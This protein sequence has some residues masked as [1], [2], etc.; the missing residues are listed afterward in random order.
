MRANGRQAAY[1]ALKPAWH[2]DDIRALRKGKHIIPRQV[3]LILSDLCNHDCSF[4]SY[5]RS[6]GYSSD[7]FVLKN[8][9]GEI[10]NRNP[11]RKIPTDKVKEIIRDCARVGVQAMQFTGGGEPTVH[12]DHL[13][14]FAYAQDSGLETSLVTNG[15]LLRP[16]WE[17]V[18]SKMKWI[19][20]SVDAGTAKTYASIRGI[21]EKGFARV[22]NNISSVVK[23]AS[24]SC[25]VGA[26]FV[27]TQD[28]Y[29]EIVEA[30]KHFKR[31]GVPYVRLSAMF[32]REGAGHY[33]EIYDAIK[34]SI[35]EAKDRFEGEEFQIV[36]LFGNRIGDLE[37]GPPDYTFCG[38]QQFNCYIGAD[39][40]V[41]R[42]CT[43]A[44]T[45]RGIVG[46]LSDKTFFNWMIS[47]ETWEAYHNFN[48]MG[49]EICQFNDKNEVINYL[50]NDS[51]THVNFV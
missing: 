8:D 11:N 46:D 42:C 19:R 39:L 28:N 4:C 34:S 49:C 22:L 27:V 30:C 31:T 20:I 48:A 45:P 29:S 12:P 47:P 41:Y 51:P 5:R 14:L 24:S 38:Y 43:T 18:F 25:L 33:S 35:A 16:G 3:Q 9:K 15:Y 17:E 2:L 37:H 36:D 21:S 32:S 26:G 50:I 1:S 40:H 13:E 6:D 23:N 7:L 10:T 44:Y